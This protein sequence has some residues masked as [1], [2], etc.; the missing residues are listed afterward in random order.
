MRNVFSELL[1]LRKKIV[2]DVG[3]GG[4]AGGSFQSAG[5]LYLKSH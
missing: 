3:D 5:A 2:F 4:E 1:Y